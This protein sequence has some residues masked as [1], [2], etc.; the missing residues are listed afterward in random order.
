[1][2]EIVCGL[3]YEF[4]WYRSFSTTSSKLYTSVYLNLHR[5]V[6]VQFYTWQ[7]IVASIENELAS[8]IILYLC[9]EAFLADKSSVTGRGRL[10]SAPC[11]KLSYQ[12]N[13]CE[14]TGKGIVVHPDWPRSQASPFFYPLVCVQYN[15][16]TW[17]SSE[18]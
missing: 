2:A 17:K 16:W 6:G 18:K 13:T 11:R 15:T 4:R 5:H 3:F 7:C 8:E 12:N 9:H 1:M 14:V 10:F